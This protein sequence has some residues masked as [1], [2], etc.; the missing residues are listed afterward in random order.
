MG[1]VGAIQTLPD[2]FFG[3]IAGA[4]ADRSDRK[5][6]M[7]LADLAR[8][9]L[10]AM[11]PLSV[12]LDGPTMAVVV[13][14]T[15]PMAVCRSFF[16]AGYTSSMPALV[17]RS[18]LGRANSYFEVI[19]SMGFIIGPVIAGL[20]AASIGPGPTL[21]IDALSFALS[22]LAIALVRRELR[23]PVDRPRGPI[24]TEI[25]EGIDYIVGSPILRSAI[26]FWVLT[27]VLLAPLVTA[28]T[29]QITVDLGYAPSI[30]GLV[31]AAYGV[32]TV[33]GSLASARLIVRTR[34]AEVFIG[35]NLV[36]G[37]AL[38]VLAA[39]VQVPVLFAVA[40]VAGI[41]QSMVL[42][43]YL[44]LR[45]TYS[46]DELLGRIGSTA[47]TFS[48]G[49]QPVGLLVGGAL[50]DAT[51]GATTIALIG[52]AVALVGLA[53]V[54]VAALRHASLAPR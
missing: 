6:M 35:G 41:A 42:V 8:A 25:R 29:V 15:A 11:I 43:M 21:A 22:S 49:L 53:F 18:Q 20:L 54:P 38:V 40:F 27:A 5:R 31:L 4:I 24:V 34:V 7:F 51:S 10:T 44:T 9:V 16:L 28:L 37:I 45:T 14:V 12:A 48:L 3:M 36:M 30:L 47:R 52:G 17:G 13:V 39:S 23:A 32:G 50:I 19:F 1:V 26:T 2:L 33:I 46:P